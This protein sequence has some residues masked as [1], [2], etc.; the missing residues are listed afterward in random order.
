MQL[1]VMLRTL[2]KEKGY[3]LADVSN[4]TGLSVSF[5]SD[6]ERG[7]TKPSLDTL[8]KLA[9]FYSIAVNEILGGVDLTDTSDLPGFSQ[10]LNSFGEAEIDKDLVDLTLQVER[11]AND[12]AETP[13]QWREYYYS[14]K[15]IL[16]R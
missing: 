10:F 1:G 13:E 4:R 9:E 7:R 3:T 14:L 15:R 6:A 5:L 12:R 11:C 16:G 2:R 8:N